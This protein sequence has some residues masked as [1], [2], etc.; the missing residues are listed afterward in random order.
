MA[1]LGSVTLPG[2]F[3]W[4]D[5]FTDWEPVAQNSEH[6]LS[7]ALVVEEGA[8]LAG[9]PITLAGLWLDRA[10]LEAVDAL[11]AVPGAKYTLALN[12]G[13]SRSVM[14][15]RG[16][17]RS[18]EARAVFNRAPGAPVTYYETTIRLMEV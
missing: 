9:R 2:N 8:R 16:S 12:D 13:S 17:G 11:A 3:Y 10:T 1:M 4:P 15:R 6:T 7:G 14:F 5:E 18:V